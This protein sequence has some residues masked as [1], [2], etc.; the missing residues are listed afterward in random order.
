MDDIAFNLAVALEHN[1]EFVALISEDALAGKPAWESIQASARSID[2]VQVAHSKFGEINHH[3]IW[4]T[5]RHWGCEPRV[6]LCV[7]DD[8]LGYSA[9]T[10]RR[11]FSDDISDLDAFLRRELRNFLNRVVRYLYH[12]ADDRFM[13]L[14]RRQPEYWFKEQI[15]EQ[16]QQTN[17]REAESTS[18]SRILRIVRRKLRSSFP[19][20]RERKEQNFRR[21][22]YEFGKDGIHY[23]LF[24][25]TGC[26]RLSLVIFC[27]P[28]SFNLQLVN[29]LI[30]EKDRG[31][32][33]LKAEELVWTKNFQTFHVEISDQSGVRDYADFMSW[34]ETVIFFRTALGQLESAFRPLIMSFDSKEE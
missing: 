7:V 31:G 25:W 4:F 24:Y 12:R 18:S 10:L 30:A 1:F 27:P 14:M 16:K 34:E 9:E 32:S 15:A 5:R 21:G 2:I 8:D 20:L 33:L 13:K 22:G 29:Y 28:R 3:V 19:H 17:L 11:L 26:W 23:S 6:R